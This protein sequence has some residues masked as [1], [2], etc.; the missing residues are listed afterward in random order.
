VKRNNVKIPRSDM[1]QVHLPD[2]VLNDIEQLKESNK[3]LVKELK[4]LRKAI[5]CE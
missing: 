2:P 1:D 4:E 5:G 3:V